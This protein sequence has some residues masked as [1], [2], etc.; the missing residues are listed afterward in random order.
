MET[1]DIENE[2]KVLFLE[3]QAHVLKAQ[4]QQQQIVGQ[5]LQIALRALGTQV[6]VLLS[7]LLDAGMFGWAMVAGT[8][9]RIAS[10]VLFSVATWCLVKITPHKGDAHA[11]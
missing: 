6:L 1:V 7:L 9:P 3:Q 11:S 10:A 4:A 8:W 2:A 5:L